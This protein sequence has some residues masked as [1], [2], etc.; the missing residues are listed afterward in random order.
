MA[1]IAVGYLT[2]LHLPFH[3]RRHLELALN[4]LSD[5]QIKSLYL[6]GDILDMYWCHGHGAKHPSPMM[7]SSFD[8]EREAGVSFLDRLDKLW[9][10]IP[11][12]FVE[13]NH[14]TRFER[15][16]VEKA[17]ALFGVTEMRRMLELDRR[18]NWSYY[19]FGPRQLVRVEKTNLFAKHAPKGSSG[20][21]IANKAAC[22]LLF[23][24]VHRC[25]NEHRVSADGRRLQIHS[26]GWLGDNR[27]DKVFGYV[28]GHHDWQSGFDIIW[29]DEATNHWWIEHIQIKNNRCIFQGKIYE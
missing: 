1:L 16:I 4:V 20:N 3:N 9:P 12:H 28:Q 29:I 25:M 26:P 2:D 13:G 5:A 21:T 23:G 17:P 24:H 7:L 10:G 8:K 11:K 14:E 6:G 19:D 22:N 27:F 15:W 18:Q